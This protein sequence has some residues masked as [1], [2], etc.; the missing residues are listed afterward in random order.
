M[1]SA[2]RPLLE[3]ADAGQRIA[4]ARRAMPNCPRAHGMSTAGT[5]KNADGGSAGGMMW[6]AAPLRQQS[7]AS[8]VPEATAHKQV[9]TRVAPTHTLAAMGVAKREGLL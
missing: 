2:C 8:W 4:R 9:G 5:N 3:R 6:D 7:P 1:T